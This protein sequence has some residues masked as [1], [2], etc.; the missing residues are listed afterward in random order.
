[1]S[2]LFNLLITAIVNYTVGSIIVV[3]TFIFS[4]PSFLATYSPSFL[5]GTLFF[6]VAAIAAMALIASYLALIYASG[7]AVI[8]T[9]A[10]FVN[11]QRRRIT[12][13]QQQRIY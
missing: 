9:T 4:L 8:Y 3:L 5:S 7:A 13:E 12:Y 1:M 10:S 11:L 2:L 6:G